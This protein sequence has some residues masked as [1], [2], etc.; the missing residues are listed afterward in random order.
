MQQ[1]APRSGAG[2]FVGARLP[3]LYSSMR[4][5]TLLPLLLVALSACGASDRQAT[6]AAATADSVRADSAARARQDS[7]NRTLPGYVIDSIFPPE[8]ELRRFRAAV[9][10]TPASAFAGGSGSLDSLIHRFVTALSA[11]DTLALRSMAVG[12]REFG[13]IYYP[14]SPYSHAPYRQS[15]SLAWRLIQ[16]PSDKGLRRLLERYSGKPLV[17]VSHSCDPKV[18]HEGRT[19][20][21]AGCLV[22]LIEPA[23]IT[24]TRRYFGSIVETRGQFKF[25]SYSNQF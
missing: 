4:R 7:V 15:P 19:T 18:A 13:D 22:R 3:A 16:D 21:Y 9:G 1:P 14:E 20:R 5:F 2:C 12:A 11:G 10:G 6:A 17:Y 23:G 24:V 25:L 8:E